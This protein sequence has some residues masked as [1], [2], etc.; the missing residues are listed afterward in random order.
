MGIA[1]LTK[2][3]LLVTALVMVVIGAVACFAGYRVFRVLLALQGFIA[4]VILGLA[5]A[6]SIPL[7]PDQLTTVRLILGLGGGLIGAAV[8][9]LLF[10][11]AVFLSGAAFGVLI[12]NAV[13]TNTGDPSRLV[14]ILVLALVGGIVALSFQKLFIVVSTAFGGALLAVSGAYRFLTGQGNNNDLL[15]NPGLLLHPN[16]AQTLGNVY[17][18]LLLVGVVLAVIGILVQYRLVYQ[19]GYRIMT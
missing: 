13:A 2:E 14:L 4:G 12:A 1:G 5:L 19:R 9:W 6:N 18:L 17:T 7:A 15:M 11:V 10:I 3:P 16:A 8:A